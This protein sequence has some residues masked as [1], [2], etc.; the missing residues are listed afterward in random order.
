M[1]LDLGGVVDFHR[2]APARSCIHAE[3]RAQWEQIVTT[4]A[5]TASTKGRMRS[6]TLVVCR[7]MSLAARNFHHQIVEGG[8]RTSWGASNS[9]GP[10]F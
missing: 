8:T 2:S 10:G 5:A 9:I 4:G 6:V 3:I 7:V 1:P